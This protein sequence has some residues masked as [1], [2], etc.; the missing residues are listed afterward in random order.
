MN[1][2]QTV[3]K[4][5]LRHFYSASIRR[6]AASQNTPVQNALDSP[7]IVKKPLKLRPPV[8]PTVKNLEVL[9]DHPLWQFFHDKKYIRKFDEINNMGEPWS[10]AMLRRKSFEDLH[11]LWWVCIK[12]RNKL[13]RES[14]IY[15]SWGENLQSDRF[16][17]SSHKIRETQWRI[18]HVLAERYH[19]HIRGLHKFNDGQR[20]VLDEFEKRYLEADSSQDQIMEA[21]LERLQYA[22]FGINPMLEDTIPS[23][24][25][26]PGLKLVARLKLLRF[27]D[28]SSEVSDIQDINEAFIL[29]TAEHSPEGVSD[30]IEAV[31]EYRKQSMPVQPPDEYKVLSELMFNFEKERAN[32]QGQESELDA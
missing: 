10:V 14:Q 11:T 8:P 9:D 28:A 3:L 1:T 21:Q 17:E 13:L 31:V 24:T 29:F 26:I 7:T 23:G 18:R 30:A 15:Q 32:L 27:R 2:G 22:L 25:V 5:G 20:E 12:E 19:G 6:A 16:K 4:R